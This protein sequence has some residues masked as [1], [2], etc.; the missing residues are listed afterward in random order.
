MGHSLSDLLA[1]GI[2]AFIAMLLA[3]AFAGGIVNS[4]RRH[5]RNG[6]W[7]CQIAAIATCAYPILWAWR[8]ESS[9]FVI[10]V[11]LLVWGVVAGLMHYVIGLWYRLE[12]SRP[13]EEVA[14]TNDTDP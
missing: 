4:H 14:E 9:L 5:L 12:I 13:K 8:A 7:L 11:A 2:G 10:G 6:T 1:A 3:I